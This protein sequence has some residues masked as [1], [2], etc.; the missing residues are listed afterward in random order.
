MAIDSENAVI[1]E[2]KY[3]EVPFDEKE[4]KDLQNSASDIIN[5]FDFL[6]TENASKRDSKNLISDFANKEKLLNFLKYFRG[7]GLVKLP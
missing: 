2:C 3:T 7:R 4:L 1:C 5:L 6:S